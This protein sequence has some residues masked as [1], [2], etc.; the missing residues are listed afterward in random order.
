MCLSH[1]IAAAQTKEVRRILILNEMDTSYPGLRIV[2][3]GI[4][5]ALNDSPYQL[6]LYSEHMDT[7]LFPDPADQQQVRAFYIRKYQNRKPDVI[8]T[9]GPSPL[10]FME[11]VHQRVFPGV[12]IVFCV[13]NANAPGAPALDSDFTGVENDMAPAETVQIGLQLQPGT[14]NVVVVGGVAPFDREGLAAV[15]KALKPYEGSLDISYLTNLAV[16]DLLKRLQHLPNHTL[17]LLTS[18]GQDAAGTTFKANEIGPLVAAAANAP[19]FGLFDVYLNHGEVGGYLSSL[20][21]QGKVAGS[22]AL[23]MLRGE[24][25]RDIPRVK[26]VNTYMFDWRALKRWGLKESALPPGSIVLNRQLTVW[27]STGGTSLAGLLCSWAKQYSFS[28]WSGSGGKKKERE[29]QQ[30]V[31]SSLARRHGSH[32]RTEASRTN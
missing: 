30:R 26:G 13:P 14:K 21:E 12:P 27:E 19:V 31:S 6:Q 9:V 28:R 29:V 1:P 11:E 4:Q 24:K 3:D 20:S 16:P 2:N 7:S 18:V 8:I 5:A 25:P 17:V 32:S 15:K 10:Q 23:R 22:M